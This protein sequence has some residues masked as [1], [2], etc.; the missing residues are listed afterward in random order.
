ME[1]V[2]S[3]LD[4]IVEDELSVATNATEEEDDD[5]DDKYGLNCS[6]NQLLA[7]ED[8]KLISS[9]AVAGLPLLL[10]GAEE[11][12]CAVEELAA[13]VNVGIDALFLKLL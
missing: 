8:M 5:D 12:F 3:K 1:A 2:A 13:T 7:T 11:M 9:G 6:V 10:I 4:V